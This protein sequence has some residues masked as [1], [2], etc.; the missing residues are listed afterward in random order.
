[1]SIGDEMPD[2]L[3]VVYYNYHL[4]LLCIVS[5]IKIE[6]ENIPKPPGVGFQPLSHFTLILAADKKW[7]S[8]TC[9]LGLSF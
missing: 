8:W 2:S 4:F 3:S 6:V 7:C 5:D 9:G 1:V